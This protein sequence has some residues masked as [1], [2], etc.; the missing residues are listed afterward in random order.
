MAR[1]RNKMSEEVGHYTRRP[2]I[3][4]CFDEALKQSPVPFAII[5]YDKFVRCRGTT[6]APAC[7][8]RSARNA[9]PTSANS[10][11]RSIVRSGTDV[12][13]SSKKHAK[14]SRRQRWH[15]FHCSTRLWLM[16]V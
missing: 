7:C 14:L 8:T 9:R 3:E 16:L 13:F 15:H 2:E 11:K 10:A 6:D 4:A 1:P 12:H 5:S